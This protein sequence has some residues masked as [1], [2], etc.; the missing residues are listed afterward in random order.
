MNNN[1]IENSN[2]IFSSNCVIHSIYAELSA[3]IAC[4]SHKQCHLYIDKI[5]LNNH[6]FVNNWS[7]NRMNNDEINGLIRS[8]TNISHRSSHNKARD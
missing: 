2:L 5:N 8:S 1:S 3:D 7:G 4:L 6:F